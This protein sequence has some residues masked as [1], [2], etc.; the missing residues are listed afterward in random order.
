MEQLWRSIKR[1]TNDR[2]WPY[3]E[4]PT[5][6]HGVRLSEKSGKFLLGLRFTESDPD[7]RLVTET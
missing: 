7:R 5:A 3:P 4:V 2:S 6:V 1:L